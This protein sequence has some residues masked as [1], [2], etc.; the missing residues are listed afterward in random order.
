MAERQLLT[1]EQVAERLQIS[2]WTVMDSLRA[3]RLKGRKIGKFW[4][5]EEQDL[6]AF[7]QGTAAA[8]TVSLD[9]RDAEDE[10]ARD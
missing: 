4:R 6:E 1:P 9:F 5:I 2:R 10:S 7:I 3:G 8:S